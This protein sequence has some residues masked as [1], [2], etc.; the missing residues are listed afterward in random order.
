MVKPCGNIPVN[1]S[2]IVTILIFP[3]LTESDTTA[4]K[5]TVIFAGEYM[6]AQSPCLDFNATDFF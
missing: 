1:A 4:F 3:D 5:G 2:Y 6:P